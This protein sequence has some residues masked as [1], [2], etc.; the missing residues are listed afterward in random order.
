M[1]S[2]A[3]RAAEAFGELVETASSRV[4][5][6]ALPQL[7]S[8][9]NLPLSKPLDELELELDR[10]GNGILHQEDFVAFVVNLKDPPLALSAR[11]SRS[12]D[13]GDGDESVSLSGLN[14]AELAKYVRSLS[15]SAAQIASSDIHSAAW[16]GDLA[17]VKK[18]VDVDRTL[19]DSKDMSEFGGDFTPLHYACY[20]GHTDIAR[21][22]LDKETVNMNAK[23]DTNCTPLFFAAQQGHV[24]LV[25][26]LLSLGA[27]VCARET[28][29]NF[30]ALDVA[31]QHRNVFNSFK[32]DAYEY[33]K[34]R[35][36]PEQL[37]APRV[38]G[39]TGVGAYSCLRVELPGV[40]G[41]DRDGL[42]LRQFKIKVVCLPKG[43]IADLLIAQRSEWDGG[44]SEETV[45]VT[46]L[47][48]GAS[49]G[50]YVCGV[51]GMG[52][53]E[54]SEMSAVVTTKVRP[55]KPV[56]VE[57]EV[58]GE[59]EE[60][61]KK[62]KPPAP[63]VAAKP[64]SVRPAKVK[65]EGEEQEVRR[66]AKTGEKS[67][68]SSAKKSR[69]GA[70]SVSSKTLPSLASAAS[71]K[72]VPALPLKKVENLNAVSL[73]SPGLG[74]N[75]AGGGGGDEG[76]DESSEMDFDNLAPDGEESASD[77]ENRE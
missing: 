37:K 45:V 11:S 76:S 54:Y 43:N 41:E 67:T 24:E 30:T 21:F 28:E 64:K 70:E 32:D 15:T 9:L 63:P 62:Q 2:W 5:M 55:V 68:S 14:A 34:W 1:S 52:C 19:V 22:L 72:L 49:Y 50:V 35:S 38:A 17:L 56:V 61:R 40:E 46:G 18:F 10:E 33:E 20:R 4:E 51:N 48:A 31:R 53:G 77:E 8:S 25:Q 47:Q 71:N 7:L 12:A 57:E 13:D 74:L 3:D 26:L 75:K 27:D 44:G 6:S 60:A 23:T 65:G 29:M 42:R 59:T 58:K 16:N 66:A 69:G 39:G 73:P 36:V